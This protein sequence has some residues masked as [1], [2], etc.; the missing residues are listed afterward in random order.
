MTIERCSICPRECKGTRFAQGAEQSFCGLPALPRIIKAQ[1]SSAEEP[2][3]VAKKGAGNIIFVG[4]V[5]N[6]FESHNIE[7]EAKNRSRVYDSESLARLFLAVQNKGAENINLINPTPYAPVIIDAL[8]R[9][10]LNI[11]VIYSSF[12][13]DSLAT[14]KELDGLIDI[15]APQYKY[16]SSATASKMAA[17]PDYP[18]KAQIALL[19]MFRQ[20]G[21]LKKDDKG[22]IEQGLLI[23]HLV[24]SNN[25]K[26]SIAALHWFSSYLPQGAGISI[27]AKSFLPYRNGMIKGPQQP[28]LKREYERVKTALIDL[29]LLVGYVQ[30]RDTLEFK[31]IKECFSFSLPF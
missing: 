14:L 17:T 3:L 9:Q 25:Y 28:P 24:L 29:Q 16:H 7:V 20:V 10:P 22:K 30:N 23:R 19:E 6:D 27:L 5:I 12:G 21:P 18:A 8:R 31:P 26:E 4:S 1:L 15:Y 2:G 11:P 13:Y